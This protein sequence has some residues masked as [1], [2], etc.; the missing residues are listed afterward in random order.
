MKILE[1]VGEPSRLARGA[2]ATGEIWEQGSTV[3][4]TIVIVE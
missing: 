4:I 3:F 2:K 1:E